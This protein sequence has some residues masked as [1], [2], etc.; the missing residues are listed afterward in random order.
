MNIFLSFSG[1]TSQRVADALHDWLPIVLHY[2]RPFLSKRDIAPGGRWALELGKSLES[3][4]FGILCLTRHGL[5]SDWLQFEAGAL[6]KYVNESAVV[7]YLFRLDV[8]DLGGPLAQFQAKKAE[9]EAT[10]EVIQAINQRHT[11]PIEQ[12]RLRKQFEALWITLEQKF[13]TIPKEEER[14]PVRPTEVMMEDLFV[15]VR[16]LTSRFAALEERILSLA[17]SS[18]AATQHRATLDAVK[19]L[20]RNAEY[21][22]S[23]PDSSPA[24]KKSARELAAQCQRQ[25]VTIFKTEILSADDKHLAQRLLGRAEAILAL[26]EKSAALETL[27]SLELPERRP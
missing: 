13:D 24:M 20:I 11:E 14:T 21:L 12:A 15:N 1:K 10:F 25:I 17:V 9:K 26:S 16:D 2:A 7:P 4:T 27:K 3:T 19:D 23:G 8:S 5:T 6:S 18:A 22:V